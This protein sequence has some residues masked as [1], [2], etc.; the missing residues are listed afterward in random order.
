MHVTSSAA[1]AVF[2]VVLAGL[3]LNGFARADDKSPPEVSAVSVPS[4]QIDNAI[5]ELDAL[6]AKA[7]SR[8]GIPGMAVA[9]VRDG[10]VAYAKGFGVR[11]VGEPAAVDADTV[12]QLASLSKP[13]PA[14]SWRTRSPP[15]ACPGIHRS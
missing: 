7:M 14:R 9:V 6:A 3:L 10:K 2:A 15:A 11:K 4:G 12:F 8:S 5:G 13:I 1:C